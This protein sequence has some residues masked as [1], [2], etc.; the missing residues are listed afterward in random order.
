M[1]GQPQKF[2][3][4]CPHCQGSGKQVTKRCPV[5]QGNKIHDKLKVIDIKIPPKFQGK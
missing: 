3:G 2:E 4:I 1:Y 5:C